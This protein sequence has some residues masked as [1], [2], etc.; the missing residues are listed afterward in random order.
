MSDTLGDDSGL[1]GTRPGDNKK[2]VFAVGDGV[3]LGFVRLQ[4]AG[5][6][7]AHFEERG[8]D[9]KRVTRFRAKRKRKTGQAGANLRLW[10]RLENLSVMCRPASHEPLA[11]RGLAGGDSSVEFGGFFAGDG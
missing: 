6:G 9:L 5:V 1:A 3:A 8:H 4:P 10:P 7:Q 11:L 2:G